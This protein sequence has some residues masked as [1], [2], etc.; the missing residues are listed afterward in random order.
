ML[1]RVNQFRWG[2][3]LTFVVCGI[4]FVG[5]WTS[6]KWIVLTISLFGL[7]LILQFLGKGIVAV[8]GLWFGA[9]LTLQTLLSPLLI[10]D[11]FKTLQPEL[12]RQIDV[13]PGALPGIEGIQKITTDSMG[14]RVT[15]PIDYETKP[16]DTYRVFAIGGSTTEQILLDDKR[17][18]T[19]LLQEQLNGQIK[20]ANVEVINTGVAGLRAEH[21][22]STF[23]HIVEFEPD[24]AI[25]L[26]GVNDWNWH[27]HEEFGRPSRKAALFEFGD[28]LLGRTLKTVY[29]GAP[30]DGNVP[31]R[32]SNEKFT[33]EY[34]SSQNDSLRRPDVRSFQPQS[35][36]PDYLDT[37]DEISLACSETKVACMFVTQPSGYHDNT[38]V[39][40]KRNFW[41]TPP[42]SD[43]T[44]DFESLIG[45][46][47][48][49]NEYLLRYATQHGHLSCDAAASVA[50]TIDSFFDDCHFN[51]N[52]AR[53]VSSILHRCITSS[54]EL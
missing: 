15:K 40:L 16:P 21:H 10:D 12:M 18:W 6:A 45:L 26:V 41:M 50:P 19:H 11:S 42:N 54:M 33:G 30:R 28:S 52:G 8:Y 27:V 14:F 47:K 32:L 29:Y 53:V 2:L 43:Y 7:P 31:A 36:H 37:M 3:A 51:E 24:L 49:Y 5:N 13:V 9:F 23:R 20:F 48:L 46:A 17:T 25:F 38:A 34:Y 44:L 4:A 22:L 35:P 39:E 1:E